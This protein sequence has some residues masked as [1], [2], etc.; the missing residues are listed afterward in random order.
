MTN[1]TK[2]TGIRGSRSAPPTNAFKPGGPPGPGR[3][4]MD[5]ELK[6]VLAANTLP[7]YRK[8]EALAVKAE[9]GGDLRT[10]STIVLALLKKS[11]PDATEFV[12]SMP[13]GLTMRSITIDPRKLKPE[14]LAAVMAVQV[15]A[16]EDK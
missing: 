13:E 9:D 15:A 16:K 5:P 10:A 2:T 4:P 11:L 6:A 3:P 1:P 14:H 7:L 12:I 8:A